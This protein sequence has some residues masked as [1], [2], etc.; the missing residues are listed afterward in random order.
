MSTEDRVKQIIVDQLGVDPKLPLLMI[1]AQILW[2]LS[3]WLW[4]SKRNLEWKFLMK[5]PKS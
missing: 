3:S 4:L 5:K 1:W 2:T